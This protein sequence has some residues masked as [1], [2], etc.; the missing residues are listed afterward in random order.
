MT[1]GPVPIGVFYDGGWFAHVSDYYAHHHPWHARISL[2]GLHDILRWHLH[3]VTGA[4]LA[5]CV[6]AE[7]HY[8]RGRSATPSRSFERI[9]QQA[10]VE[11]H[12]AELGAFWA[13]YCT[14]AGEPLLAWGD[15][16]SVLQAIPADDRPIITALGQAAGKPWLDDWHM[17]MRQAAGERQASGA[18]DLLARIGQT[19]TGLGEQ[20]GQR[21]APRQTDTEAQP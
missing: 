10:G 12:D 2:Q 5:D 11:R 16:A 4:P 7:A 19:P 14:S 1:G 3:A 9:L 6:V 21:P 20:A 13:K 15:I 8:V 17:A 18:D